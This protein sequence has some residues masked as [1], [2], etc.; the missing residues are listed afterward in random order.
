MKT[1]ISVQRAVLTL[2]KSFLTGP[3]KDG[4]LSLIDGTGLAGS[5]NFNMEL[6]SPSRSIASRARRP[7][8]WLDG[9]L[10]RQLNAPLSVTSK[11]AGFTASVTFRGC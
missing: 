7:N 11:R 5:P 4:G 8:R 1:N 3:R 2:M 10:D 9:L 6:G